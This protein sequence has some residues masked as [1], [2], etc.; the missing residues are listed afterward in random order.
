MTNNEIHL[1]LD[2]C[3]PW[4]DAEWTVSLHESQRNVTIKMFGNEEVAAKDFAMREG[5]ERGLPVVR[6]NKS[7]TRLVIG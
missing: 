7:G 5:R 2:D 4:D 3:D 1:W 6:I